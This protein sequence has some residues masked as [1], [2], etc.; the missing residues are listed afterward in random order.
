MKAEETIKT[1]KE[2]FD[3]AQENT[4][5]ELNVR[6]LP[7]TASQLYKHLN[8][9]VY[10][11]SSMFILVLSGTAVSE[12][13]FKK[14]EVASGKII[15]LSFGHFFKIQQM[16][17]DF[18]CMVLY[19]SNE[20]IDEMFSGEMI[21]KR[22]KYGVK[23]HKTPLLELRPDESILLNQRLDFIGKIIANQQHRYYKEMILSA[24]LIFFLDLSQIIENEHLEEGSGKQSRDEYY[25]HQFL[26][27]LVTNYK[28]RHHV[29]FYADKLNI[30]S[31]YLT[32]IV[33]RLSGQTVSD[34][35]FQLLFS[36]AKVLLQQPN[37]PIQDITAEFH[38]SD[39]SAFGKFFKRKS[40]LSPKEHRQK[41]NS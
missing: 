16:S 10:L 24:L 17:I 21:Y 34:L 2:L 29:E 36:E 23:T 27:I 32:L 1:E 4:R 11:R 41:M 3:D 33:K 7:L 19:V 15:L 38:F 5:N 12:I 30:T 13:N 40:G 6:I 8:T 14:H 39:Q 22:V 26:E 37:M 35:I 25:F 9:N 28:S 31:H 18:R 20:Y